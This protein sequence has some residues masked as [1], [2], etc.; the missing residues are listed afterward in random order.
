MR[1]EKGFTLLEVLI[2]M[3]ILGISISILVSGFSEVSDSIIKGQ[4]YT[5]LSTFANSKLREVAI[6]LELSY[7]GYVDYQGQSYRW[8]I[9]TSYPEE[10]NLEKLELIIQS[11]TGNQVYSVERLIWVKQ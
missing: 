1:F 4:E 8:Y 11:P 10:R 2:A 5:Y 7:S 3:T 9:N 6:G